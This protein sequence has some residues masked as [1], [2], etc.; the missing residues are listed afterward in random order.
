M[1]RTANVSGCRQDQ[2]RNM[3]KHSVFVGRSCRASANQLMQA[4]L[5][6]PTTN[7]S[8]LVVYP[9]HPAADFNSLLAPLKVVIDRNG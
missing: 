8:P 7:F 2:D 3:T 4:S 5:R 1:A 9:T 6:R